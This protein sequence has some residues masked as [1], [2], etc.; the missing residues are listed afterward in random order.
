MQRK[1]YLTA[2]IPA[3]KSKKVSAENLGSGVTV[4]ISQL[5][6]TETF[7]Q[8]GL[9]P[10]PGIYHGNV[11]RN[12]KLVSLIYFCVHDVVIDEIDTYNCSLSNSPWARA[13]IDGI[14]PLMP[15]P[16]RYELR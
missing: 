12:V 1:T 9:P 3:R 7:W 8:V 2:I 6:F 13:T 10:D 11:K 14:N 15:S 5:P 16:M 4:C